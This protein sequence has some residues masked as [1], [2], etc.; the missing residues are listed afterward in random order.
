MYKTLYTCLHALVYCHLPDE[1][2]LV[3]CPVDF[4]ST[5]CEREPQRQLAQVFAGP[6]P[7]CHP[8]NSVKALTGMH[9]RVL[10]NFI[11]AFFDSRN[12]N[13]YA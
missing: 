3:G 2:R 7:L 5:G 1:L 13:P 6:M 12:I 11:F 8:P 4:S 9:A 10:H